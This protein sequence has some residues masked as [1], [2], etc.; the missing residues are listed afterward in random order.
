MFVRVAFSPCLR[1]VSA[2]AQLVGDLCRRELQNAEATDQLHMA[3]HELAEN[4]AKYSTASEVSLEI[5]LVETDGAFAVEIRT[6]N[7][8]SPGRLADV[9]R[10][11]H[12]LALAEDA[13]AHYERLLEESLGREGVS[14]LGLARITAEAGLVLTCSSEGNELTLTATGRVEKRVTER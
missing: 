5:E 14:G 4:I 10:R 8:T 1:H 2:I 6:R 7:Y 11:I 3:A 13:S 12:E 9:A